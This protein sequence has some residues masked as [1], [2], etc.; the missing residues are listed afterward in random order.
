MGQGGQTLHRRL[1][2]RDGQQYRPFQPG[3]ARGDARPDGKIHVRLPAALPDGSVR[4]AGGENR[5]AGARGNEPRVFRLGRVGGGGKHAQTGAAIRPDAGR[6]AAFQGDLASPE[7][8]RLHA[9]RARDHRLCADDRP[10]RSDDAADA[11]GAGAA[12]LSRRAGPGRSGDGAAL[13]RHA[14]SADSRGGPGNGAGLHPGAR[15]RRLDRGS[16]ASGGLHATHPRDLHAVRRAAD[17]RRG[18]DRRRADGSVLRGRSTGTWS[19][20]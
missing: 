8:S 3:G 11:Q 7:L 12:R 9:W 16:G 18:D 5:R 1:V 15:R 6:G 19:P 20:I 4:D 2:G 13:R 14:G 10:V 17:P